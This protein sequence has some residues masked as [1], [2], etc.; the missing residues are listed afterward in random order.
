MHH[1]M[2]N[3]LW[4]VVLVESSGADL[5]ILIQQHSLILAT[6]WFFSGHCV[7]MVLGK[8]RNRRQILLRLLESASALQ[9]VPSRLNCRCIFDIFDW[10]PMRH[11]FL[12]SF[13][14]QIQLIEWLAMRI[15][16]FQCLLI[17]SVMA[18][19]LT[20]PPVMRL[21]TRL[22]HGIQHF[23]LALSLIYQGFKIILEIFACNIW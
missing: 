4:H 23:L 9:S 17:A 18:T 16:L 5:A 11:R 8:R 15:N 19:Y 22:E 1:A 7:K 21:I 6:S 3:D 20:C 10:P 2:A 12:R 13:I 14:I